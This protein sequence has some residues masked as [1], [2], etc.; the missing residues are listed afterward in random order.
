M[1]DRRRRSTLWRMVVP[2]LMAVLLASPG[3]PSS[4]HRAG[5]RAAVALR[6]V[7]RAVS[8]RDVV[9]DGLDGLRDELRR[10]SAGVVG[11]RAFRQV[12]AERR[13]FTGPLRGEHAAMADADGVQLSRMSRSLARVKGEDS[14]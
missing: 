13:S 1:P 12:W 5:S 4:A 10:N 7:A 6:A 2:L 3:G 8:A 9:L 11:L 14:P